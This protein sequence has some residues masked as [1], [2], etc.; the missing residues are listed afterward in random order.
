M[1]LL[2]GHGVL[3]SCLLRRCIGKQSRD[4][5][6]PYEPTH[7]IIPQTVRFLQFSGCDQAPQL[8]G[9]E[10]AHG[11]IAALNEPVACHRSIPVQKGTNLAMKAAHFAA[12]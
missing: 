9:G 8:R 10:G 3:R 6:G 1:G 7:A 5:T 11:T 4:G 12:F 2:L